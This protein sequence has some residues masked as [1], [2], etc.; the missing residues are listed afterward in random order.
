MHNTK[1]LNRPF[2]LFSVLLS[3]SLSAKRCKSFTIC[4]CSTILFPE[5]VIVTLRPSCPWVMFHEHVLSYLEDPNSHFLVLHQLLISMVRRITA[6]RTDPSL[7]Y[8]FSHSFLWFDFLISSLQTLLQETSLDVCVVVFV[9]LVLFEAFLFHCFFTNI[10]LRP[11]VNHLG[12]LFFSAWSENFSSFF[13]HIFMDF[14]MEVPWYWLSPL[15][16]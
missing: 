14:S 13:P 5:F 11:T 2:S 12:N 9:S 10:I 4:F 15:Q 16:D 1:L 8:Y 7:T 3:H 6:Y